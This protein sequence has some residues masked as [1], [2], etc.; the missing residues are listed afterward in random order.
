MVACGLAV[1]LSEEA[2]EAGSVGSGGDG[3]ACEVEEVAH[4]GGSVGCGEEERADVV[5]VS[6]VDSE[7]EGELPFLAITG[8]LHHADDS[9]SDAIVDGGGSGRDLDLDSGFRIGHFDGLL[10]GKSLLTSDGGGAVSNISI[11][12]V[13]HESILEQRI[14][15]LVC[16]NIRGESKTKRI[17]QRIKIKINLCSNGGSKGTIRE[18][19]VLRKILTI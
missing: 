2:E 3:G 10:L 9:G 18:V 5:E 12:T 6:G 15:R 4:E 1:E 16:E 8:H 17:L 19:G 11:D 13:R 14:V 7:A